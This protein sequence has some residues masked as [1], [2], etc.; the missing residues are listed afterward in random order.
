MYVLRLLVNEPLPLNEGLLRAVN[1]IVPEGSF[2]NPRFNTNPADSPAVAG[3]NV[4]TSQRVVDTLLKALGIAACSQGT[5]NN[6]VFG[7]ARFGY[8]E[9]VCGGAGATPSAP[10]ESAVH[11]HMTNTRITDPEVLEHRYPVRLERFEIHTNSGGTGQNPGG[12]GILREY[13]FLEPVS[14][15]LLTQHRT[16]APYG[17]HQG[18]P[19]APGAQHLINR[20]GTTRSLPSTA[21]EELLPNTRLILQTPGGG[22][23]GLNA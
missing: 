19:G 22:G 9:T 20:D 21:A 5:M 23:W 12:D 18:S 6:V 7:N 16:T 10:G 4:E 17:L 11:T 14:L 8:Y 2:L 3:G 15:S 1:L 13:T